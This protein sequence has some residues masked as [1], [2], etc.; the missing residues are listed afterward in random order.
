MSTTLGT[1]TA[2]AT[3]KAALATVAKTAALL[4]TGPGAPIDSLATVGT[5]PKAAPLDSIS[6]VATSLTQ[7]G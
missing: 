2:K 6:T 1:G 3:A 7:K 4:A 5:A